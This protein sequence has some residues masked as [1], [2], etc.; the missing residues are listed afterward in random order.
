MGRAGRRDLL[1]LALP[2]RLGGSG[3]GFGEVATVLTEIGRGAAQTPALATLG[4]GVLPIL[5]LAS[6]Q[7][8]DDLP[9]RRSPKGPCP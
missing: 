2:E 1:S 8:Q 7:Q 4:L 6:E 5:A 3:L 9:R